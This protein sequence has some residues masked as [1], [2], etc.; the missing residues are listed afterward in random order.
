MKKTISLILA[1]ALCLSLCA[2]GGGND[3]PE[4]EPPVAEATEAPVTEAPEEPAVET[5]YQL[6]DVIETDLFQITP[7]FTGYAFEL[8]NWPDENFMTPAGKF[9]GTSAYSAN[10]GKTAMYGE[11]QIAY[12]GN[13]KSDVSLNLN[14]SVDYDNGYIFQGADVDMGNCVSIDGDWQYNGQMTFEPLSDHNTRI[15]RYCVEV[16]E[17]VETNADKSLLVTFSVNGEPFVFDFRSADVLGSDF[18]PRAEFYQPIDD[19]TKTQIVNY[20]KKHGLEHVGWYDTTVG[21]YTFTFGDT[22]V[23]A[24]LPISK[25]YQYEFK[26]TYEVFSGAILI[27][28]DYGQQMHFDYTFDGKNLDIITF[29]HDR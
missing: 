6:S 1:L 2:C 22:D 14:I 9:S 29:E 27:T 16:P 3:A 13:E 5:V 19:E 15:L 28:W 23:E 21:V 25:N 24:V 10:K 26:G 8:A 12:I 4:T 7:S 17:Q 20:L 11:V 18:D